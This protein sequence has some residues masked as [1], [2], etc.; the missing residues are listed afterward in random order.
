[1]QNTIRGS[2]SLMHEKELE[3]G[4]RKLNIV[5]DKKEE[6]HKQK[7]SKMRIIQHRLS[8]RN[9]LTLLQLQNLGDL[10]SC[11]KNDKKLG[12]S[13]FGKKGVK[14][15]SNFRHKGLNDTSN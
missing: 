10:S 2:N 3:K 7:E 5:I 9:S 4:Q 1:M 6:E 11:K 12:H 15:G 8:K 14:S 13:P